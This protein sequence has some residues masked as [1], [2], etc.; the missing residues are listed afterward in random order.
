MVID[1]CAYYIVVKKLSSIILAAALILS[2]TACKK[3]E[4][5]VDIDS[6]T[7]GTQTLQQP[8]RQGELRDP[9]HGKEL[10]FGYGA[11][12]GTK[13]I[14]ANGVSF[15]YSYEDGTSVIQL[16][17]NIEQAP[18]GKFYFGWLSQADASKPWVKVGSFISPFNDVRHSA[19]AKV[20]QHLS[21]YTKIVITVE[22]S[23]TPETPGKTV[24]TG[25]LKELKRN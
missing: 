13:G 5:A 15:R 19:T 2:F 8:M 6:E 7:I 23:E 9:V 22:D 12:T 18:R 16:T 21:A 4:Q 24:A 14:N 1:V 20:K 11:I 17:M 25:D 10:S 3:T